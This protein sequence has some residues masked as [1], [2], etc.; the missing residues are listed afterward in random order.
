MQEAKQCCTQSPGR[1][2]D[3][4]AAELTINTLVK[5]SPSGVDFCF[6]LS[7]LLI[8][9]AFNISTGK[10]HIQGQEIT[11]V[12]FYMSGMLKQQLKNK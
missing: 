10:Q 12:C 3:L 6:C 4:Q 11:E 1:D 9:T 8:P 5:H 7:I 2:S